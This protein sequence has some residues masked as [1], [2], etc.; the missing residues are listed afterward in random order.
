L[1]EAIGFDSR[2]LAGQKL[3]GQI[4]QEVFQI[5]SR[6]SEKLNPKRPEQLLV[7]FLRG[8]ASIEEDFSFRML[9]KVR[10]NRYNFTQVTLSTVFQAGAQKH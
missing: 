7:K 4:H 2:A 9:M 10:E 8:T 6:L 3:I 5:V 1:S